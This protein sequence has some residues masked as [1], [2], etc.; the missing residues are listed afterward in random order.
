MNKTAYI[1]FNGAFYNCETPI[2]NSSNRSF[3][4][5]D[6]LFETIRGL[7][8][9]LQFFDQHYARLTKGMQVL[10][11][12]IPADFKTILEQ[13]ITKTINKNRYF[14]GNRIRL[15]IF[16]GGGGLYTPASNKIAFLIEVSQLKEKQYVLN[17]RG[18]NIGLYEEVRKQPAPYASFKTANSMLF[19]MAGIYKQNNGLDDCLLTSGQG[20]IIEAISSN[21]F[22]IN[23]DILQTPPVESGI[24]RGIMREQIINLALEQNITVFEDCQ[25]TETDILKA[26]EIFLTNAVS[27]IRWVAA[28][29]QRRYFNKTAKLLIK[30]LNEKSFGNK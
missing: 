28:Y 8:T 9:S 18:L 11:M 22:I 1:N 26:D 24:V 14:G 4:Y 23:N 5:G 3:R 19:I 20:N 17:S 2:F 16:R 29:K 12:D 30:H 6:C 25:F 13:N 10:S 27:G 15:S 21:L 7:G